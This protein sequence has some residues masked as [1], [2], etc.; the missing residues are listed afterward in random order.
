MAL[1]GTLTHRKTRRL[2]KALGIPVPCALGVLEA[3]WHVTGEQA[4]DGG[5]GRMSNADLAEEMFWDD[6]ADALVEALT[7]SGWLEKNKAS[8]LYIHDWHVHSDDATD[9]FLA[10]SGTKYANGNIPRMKRLSE[11]ERAN[12]CAKWG[13]TRGEEPQD[14]MECHDVPQKAPSGSGSGSGA[15][16][17]SG[18]GETRERHK[19]RHDLWAPFGEI[20]A[21]ANADQKLAK[22][23]LDDVAA[24]FDWVP[25]E[26]LLHEAKRCAA[27]YQKPR[28]TNPKTTDTLSAPG[29]FR[30]W[31]QRE[32][33]RLKAELG[34]GK[35][36]SSLPHASQ[37]QVFGRQE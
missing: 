4:K 14:S 13:W 7:V 34:N 24:D 18:A 30:D 20:Q 19:P 12:L 37:V 26:R 21:F 23:G 11:A 5:I 33:T 3:L 17:I 29:K 8:R 35:P 28:Y 9:S 22:A 15:S 1:R 10:R 32:S 16:A 36:E 25:P 2:A 31:M 27:H 6:D